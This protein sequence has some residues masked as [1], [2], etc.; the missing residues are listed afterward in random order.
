MNPNVAKKNVSISLSLMLLLK[1]A[2][3]SSSHFLDFNSREDYKDSVKVV[4]RLR[5]TK[6]DEKDKTIIMFK[7]TTRR[8][9][10]VALE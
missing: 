9:S 1:F 7:S 2:D 6:I 8:H 3:K 10:V 4:S 5:L